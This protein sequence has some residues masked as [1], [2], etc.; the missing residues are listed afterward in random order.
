MNTETCQS[1]FHHSPACYTNLVAIAN[2]FEYSP[3]FPRKCVGMGTL[4]LV[5]E[6]FPFS[7]IK[8]TLLESNRGVILCP[9]ILCPTMRA[10]FF[11]PFMASNTLSPTL[12]TPFL[13][14]TW[15]T[16]GGRWYGVFPRG[17]LST[18]LTRVIFCIADEAADTLHKY[19]TY[20]Q[21]KS[22]SI[23]HNI[24]TPVKLLGLHLNHFVLMNPDCIAIR[25]ADPSENMHSFSD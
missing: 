13:V 12:P 17:L 9:G 5:P 7:S 15:M 1:S 3:S 19:K 21:H 18:T 23:F 10:F 14:Y 2:N 24:S 6:G 25:Q 22:L 4:I 16:R 8:T 20:T 11:C